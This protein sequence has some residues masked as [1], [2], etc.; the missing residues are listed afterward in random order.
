MKHY[1]QN[2]KY[3]YVKKAIC[4]SWPFF[5][6]N[7]WFM[8]CQVLSWSQFWSIYS[9]CFTEPLVQLRTWILL[10]SIH[11]KNWATV[12]AAAA[13]WQMNYSDLWSSAVGFVRHHHLGLLRRG[14]YKR[15]TWSLWRKRSIPYRVRVFVI[16]GMIED[17]RRG[18]KVKPLNSIHHQSCHI[19]Q[20]VNHYQSIETV[21][22]RIQIAGHSFSNLK[23][24]LNLNMKMSNVLEVSLR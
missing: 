6:W 21:I 11:T 23:S 22:I 17:V 1:D 2:D 15:L 13:L 5:C 19:L 4:G 10:L 3:C 24:N 12:T 16:E 9:Q 14:V 7:D 8:N 20:Q 18:L